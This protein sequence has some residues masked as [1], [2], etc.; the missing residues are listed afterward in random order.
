MKN[1]L[2]L[3]HLSISNR[4]CLL[5]ILFWLKLMHTYTSV[6]STITLFNILV[7]ILIVLLVVYILYYY[8]FTV[9]FSKSYF[10][11]DT[12]VYMTLLFGYSPTW[13]IHTLARFIYYFSLCCCYNLYYYFIANLSKSNFFMTL[14]YFWL[15]LLIILVLLLDLFILLLDSYII[16]RSAVVI[17]YILTIIWIIKKNSLFCD[18]SNC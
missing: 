10:F 16:A 18:I 1:S 6:W 14:K 4:Y 15:F 8:C 5:F 12:W 11:Y 9:N 13:S 2:F 17:A 7:N 3:W